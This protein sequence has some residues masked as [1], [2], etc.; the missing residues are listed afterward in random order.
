MHCE[1]GSGKRRRSKARAKQPTI[2]KR[3][4]PSQLCDRPPRLTPSPPGEQREVILKAKYD[5]LSKDK[6]QL[7]K[8]VEKKRRKEGQKEQK[9]MPEKRARA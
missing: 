8:T 6:K 4:S 2:S 1:D 5:T 7:R 9:R 3:V